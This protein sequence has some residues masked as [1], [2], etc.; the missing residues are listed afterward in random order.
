MNRLYPNCIAINGFKNIVFYDLERQSYKRFPKKSLLKEDSNH[1]LLFRLD[2]VSETGLQLLKFHQL[3]MTDGSASDKQLKNATFYKWMHPSLITNAWIELST[4][5]E[6]TCP[7]AFNKLMQYLELIRCRHAMLHLKSVISKEQLKKLIECA[8]LS[9]LHSLQLIVPYELEY[10]TDDF[11]EFIMEQPKL[12]YILF[13]A[14]PVARNLENKLYFSCERVTFSNKKNP[15]QFNINLTL[16]SEAIQYHTY[17]NRKLFI[18]EKGEIKNAPECEEIHGWIQTISEARQLEQLIKTPA[19]Q[20][21]WLV[22]KERCE[23]C[24]DCEYRYMCV[25]NRVPY[26]K[27]N[28]Y[29]SHQQI[30]NYDPYE[31]KWD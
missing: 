7:S 22:N 2:Q 21:L 18:G 13:E 26:K 17:F 30:C 27:E 11:G 24:K 5:N 3:L 12:T 6:L 15:R 19:F 1:S 9:E 20:K 28:G 16:F 31:G 10:D 4:S 14:S 23:V 25:D 29:W 8:S